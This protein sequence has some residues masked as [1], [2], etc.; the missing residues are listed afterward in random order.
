M[1]V[2]HYWAGIDE[3]GYGPNLGPLVVT[4]VVA[5]GS[6]RRPDMWGDLPYVRRVGDFQ[7]E[8]L[9]V[10]DSKRVMSRHDGLAIF[11]S[12]F[13][14]LADSLLP[15]DEAAGSRGRGRI[16]WNRFGPEVWGGEELARWS[17]PGD[18]G[19][20]WIDARPKSI[21]RKRFVCRRWRVAGARIAL[22]GPERFN[23]L[24][25]ETG[26]KSEV[27]G[28]AFLEL[29]AWLKS[30][31]PPGAVV[32]VTTDRHGGRHFYGPLLSLAFP[33]R[34]IEKID[35][36]AQTSR[37][38]I[39]DSRNVYDIAFVVKADD[40]DGLV[41]LAS[42][43]AKLLRERWMERF[44]AWFARRVPDLRP[45]AGYPVDAKRFLEDVRHVIRSERIEIDSIWRRK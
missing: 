14:A 17:E 2:P 13:S 37:Y 43:V 15:V 3:A 1:P 36:T 45:T 18:A 28:L 40:S 12:A 11:H 32:H 42:M 5:R 21:G 6:S 31:V 20:T 22:I 34:W 10:D 35:E 27:N 16:D 41:A 9:C 38:R 24:L 29:I 19:L 25:K 33:G 4:A 30:A 8:G 39:D 26:N 44:N 23:R 7:A